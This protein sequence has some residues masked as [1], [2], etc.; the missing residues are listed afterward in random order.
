M[1]IKF[2]KIS[3]YNE[4]IKLLLDLYNQEYDYPPETI[5]SHTYLFSHPDIFYDFFAIYFLT[6]AIVLSLSHAPGTLYANTLLRL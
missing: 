1:I 2:I 4:E 3:K 6:V 5:L